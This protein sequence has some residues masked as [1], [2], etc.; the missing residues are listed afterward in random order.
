MTDKTTTT[1]RKPFDVRPHPLGSIIMSGPTDNDVILGAVYDKGPGSYDHEEMAKVWA[2]AYPVMFP[3]LAEIRDGAA[4]VAFAGKEIWPREIVEMFRRIYQRA[5]DALPVPTIGDL[6]GTSPAAPAITATISP[7]MCVAA[8]DAAMERGV[9]LPASHADEIIEAALRA[10]PAS[11]PAAQLDGCVIAPA[12]ATTDI[13]AR[14]E[15]RAV[16]FGIDFDDFGGDGAIDALYRAAV[17]PYPAAPAQPAQDSL[18]ETACE[19]SDAIAHADEIGAACGPCAAEHRRLAA[20]LR[21]LRDIRATQP[22][23][24]VERDVLSEVAAERRRQI[25]VEGWAPEH[26]DEHMGG[27]L[28]AA[29]ATYALHDIRGGWFARWREVMWPWAQSWWKP[30][31]RRRNLI[32]AAALIV[33]E[34][35]RLDRAALR[36]G[37]GR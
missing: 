29:A 8:S 21:E 1:A 11:P 20:W 35:E 37:E 7:A 16:D 36:S 6:K 32:R 12:H 18:T 23:G 30:K 27:E 2:A 14:M 34:I 31:D 10:A 22:V 19:L 3:A 24:E 26:D 5:K 25:E 15:S 28:A 13:R 33:A 9:I 4:V 17:A